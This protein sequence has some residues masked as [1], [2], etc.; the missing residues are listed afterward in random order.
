MVRCQHIG[1]ISPRDNPRH[2]I[3]CIT[4]LLEYDPRNAPTIINTPGWT[5]GTGYELLTSIIEIV[6]PEFIVV[7]SIAGNDSLARSLHPLASSYQS[8]LL[9]IE[10]A[11]MI[12]P[13][14][15][16]TAAEFRTLGIMSY[17]HRTDLEEWDFGTHL[18]AW[19]PWVVNFTGSA[20]ERGIWAVAIQG[21]EVLT[22]D[23]ICAINGTL[24]AINVLPPSTDEDILYTPEGIPVFAPRET[25]FMDP[26][27]VRCVGYAIVRG[28][29]VKNGWIFLLS[30]WDPSS[31]QD[32]E[33]VVLERGRVNL[34]VWGM[35]NHQ[36]PRTLGPWLQRQ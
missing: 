32:K 8:H 36:T 28:I 3:E 34:P 7:L 15:P 17:F 12:P 5:K 10:S 31:L 13:P 26:R 35:W 6:K 30:P 22:E 21:E 24:V 29:D 2:Y 33:R 20:E 14:L 1:N 23:V 11:N 4:D 25:Q 19:K 27:N 16:L 18:T 9:I